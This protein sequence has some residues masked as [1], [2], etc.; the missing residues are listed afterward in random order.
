M[1]AVVAGC[2][3][4]SV[5]RFRLILRLIT[6]S[7][8][9]VDPARALDTRPL[10]PLRSRGSR[11]CP[12]F[13]SLSRW[14]QSGSVEPRADRWA[15]LSSASI[16]PGMMQT[17][18]LLN[19]AEGSDPIVVAGQFPTQSSGRNPSICAIGHHPLL[20]S[21]YD[22]LP[23]LCSVIPLPAGRQGFHGWGH[24]LS[25]PKHQQLAWPL[26]AELPRDLRQ[27]RL[28]RSPGLPESLTTSTGLMLTTSASV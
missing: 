10:E 15:S 4:L 14:L 25:Y 6:C 28:M 17:C 5:A 20:S 24:R 21:P 9:T 22:L 1:A 26:F 27:E 8:G 18:I 12:A 7:F 2:L 3:S 19:A 16:R 23:V 13:R 11:R